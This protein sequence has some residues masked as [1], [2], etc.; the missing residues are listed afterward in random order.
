MLKLQTRLKL[1]KL[2]C[3]EI[4]FWDKV[5]HNLKSHFNLAN[6]LPQGKLFDIGLAYG[7]EKISTWRNVFRPAKEVE[8]VTLTF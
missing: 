4:L 7:V 1:K 6:I 3:Q 2:V 5:W 8:N